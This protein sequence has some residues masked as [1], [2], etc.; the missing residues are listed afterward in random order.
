MKKCYVRVI[1]VLKDFTSEEKSKII[2]KINIQNCENT[3]KFEKIKID[4]PA[5]QESEV[6]A[7]MSA[8]PASGDNQG[9]ETAA[10]AH[11][12]DQMEI[13]ENHHRDE[14]NEGPQDVFTPFMRLI[15]EESAAI[16]GTSQEDLCRR[17]G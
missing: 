2:E 7:E 10:A 8:H 13:A 16:V 9:T 5:R 17:N 6:T 14:V 11:S 15:Q 1:N 12:Q 4:I 3:E